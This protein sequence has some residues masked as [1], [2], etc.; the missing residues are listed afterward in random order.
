MPSRSPS[1]RLPGAVSGDR[2]DRQDS[3]RPALAERLSEVAAD[4]AAS[5]ERVVLETA[6]ELLDWVLEH[7]LAWTFRDAGAELEHGLAEWKEAHAWRGAAGL[8]LD[9]LRAAWRLGEGLRR[10]G[11]EGA[12]PREVLAQEL[13]LWL[14]GRGE[15]GAGE[16]VWPVWPVWDGQPLAPGLRLPRREA[17]A[18]RVLG[19]GGRDL[20]DRGEVVF[21]P[22]FSETVCLALEA[23]NGAGLAPEVVLPEG[24]PGLEGRRGARRLVGSG[25]KVR[26]VYD[27]A[28]AG[29]LARADRVWIG[30]EAIGVEGFLG[31]VG[32]RLLC[33]E[34]ERREV[35]V[36]LLAT[37]DKLVPGGALELP[38][39]CRRD[40]WLL[41]EDAPDG[42]RLDP[43]A[44]EVV[45]HELCGCILTEEG[46][47]SA[48]ALSMRRL[49]V[50]PQAPCAAPALPDEL[51]HPT[52]DEP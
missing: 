14:A 34:A 33:E 18:A 22:A 24:A 48:A 30:T 49:R 2:S 28:F 29:L 21:V 47:E 7:E 39:W 16:P 35:P 15:E 5:S 6:G 9:A 36:Q 11:D 52:I 23:A 13:G 50:E 1:R 26:Y 45:P 17:L 8:F 42:V 43:Q 19:P 25:V 38:G 41:W 32:T 4:R 3:V 37:S 31:R 12:T 20:I 40:D 27:A 44:Y 46:V 51:G 10:A